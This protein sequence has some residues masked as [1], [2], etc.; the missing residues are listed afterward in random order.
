[1]RITVPE[2]I[3]RALQ[4]GAALSISMSGGKDSQ[5][6]A[7]AL[8]DYL[9]A[10]DLNNEVFAIH[11]DLG[12]MEWSGEFATDVQVQRQADELG[13]PLV[14]VTRTDGRDLPDHPQLF[15]RHLHAIAGVAEGSC[16]SSDRAV[17]LAGV[18]TG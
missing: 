4:D 17:G 16:R 7:R 14:V 8:V 3:G 6:M 12:R 18:G 13:L 15:R 5:A 2:E 11:A 1:M 9:E 10:E